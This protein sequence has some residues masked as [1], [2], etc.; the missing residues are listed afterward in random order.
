M[1]NRLDS[2]VIE[3]IASCSQTIIN[4]LEEVG[5]TELFYEEMYDIFSRFNDDYEEIEEFE[6]KVN[7]Y[8]WNKIEK[9][10]KELNSDN[11]K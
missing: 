10:D 2:S 3:I 5:I 9:I 1:K 8:L 11:Y 7:D 4:K 6:N